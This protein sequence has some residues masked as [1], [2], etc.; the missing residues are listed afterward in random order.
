ML[1]DISK[2]WEVQ[3]VFPFFEFHPAWMDVVHCPS[4]QS[5]V[6]SSR[7]G[8]PTGVCASPTTVLVIFWIP[9]RKVV[10]RSNRKQIFPR[11]FIAVEL[12]TVRYLSI[13]PRSILMFSIY[14]SKIVLRKQQVFKNSPNMSTRAQTRFDCC[15]RWCLICNAFLCRFTV[16]R[17]VRF[18]FPETVHILSILSDS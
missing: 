15:T 6:E 12:S 18:V 16:W 11:K 5:I 17:V 9:R 2:R 3:L 14:L 8:S 4:S 7:C 1:A 13:P 10:L